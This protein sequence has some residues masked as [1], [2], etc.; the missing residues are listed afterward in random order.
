MIEVATP[1]QMSC[2]LL[3]FTV[4]IRKGDSK[5]EAWSTGCGQ[6]SSLVQKGHVQLTQDRKSVV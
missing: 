6:I 2:P 5:P 4:L 1:L 3:L